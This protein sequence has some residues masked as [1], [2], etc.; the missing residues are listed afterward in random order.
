MKFAIFIL[1]IFTCL[2]NSHADIEIYEK[3]LPGYEKD[4]APKTDEQLAIEDA[5]RDA[6]AHVNPILWFSSGCFFPIISPI[7]SQFHYGKVPS[8]RLIG[9]S[10]TYVAF[11]VDNYKI[12][13]KKQRFNYALGGCLL[14]TALH[15]GI[16]GIII[17][18]RSE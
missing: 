3:Y 11:Y 5:K 4:K 16:I 17:D 12:A 8:A 15:G 9:K 14:G 7:L 18:S 2:A 1:L 6:K 10:P 13:I